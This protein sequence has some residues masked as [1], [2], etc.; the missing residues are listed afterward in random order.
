[1]SDKEQLLPQ[2]QAETSA[3]DFKKYLFKALSNWYLFVIGIALALLY[4]HWANKQIIPSYGVHTTLI[5]QNKGQQEDAVAGGLR[6]FSGTGSMDTEMGILQSYSFN[7][8][9]I[10]ELDFATSYFKYNKWASDIELYKKT[11]FIVHYDSLYEQHNWVPVY[12]TIIDS[13]K[14]HLSIETFEVETELNFGEQFKYGKFSFNITLNKDRPFN[15][16]LTKNKYFFYKL[17]INSLVSA[18]KSKLKIE[19]VPEGSS[20]LWIWTMG[21]VKEKEADYL[22]KLVEIF[23]RQRL[24]E[25]N[26]RAVSIIEFIDKQIEGV[27]DSLLNTEDR[28]QVFKQN[29]STL[30]I[31]TEAQLLLSRQDQIDASIS[32]LKSRKS[33]YEITYND[34]KQNKDI[35]AVMMPT[36]VGIKD[37][38]IE[39]L[40]S[41]LSNTIMEREILNFNIAPGAN[42][43]NTAVLD[44]KI[45]NIRGQILNHAKKSVEA[46]EKNI[47][48]MYK[49]RQLIISKIYGL[50]RS[51]RR[52][53]SIERRFNI[54]DKI[55]TNLITRRIEAEITQASTKA[56]AKILDT[57]LAINAEDLTQPK[58][59]NR[60]K[61]LL[62]G[63][64]IPILIIV[65]K[66][67][68]NVT[69][70]DK[71]EI[72]KGT[73]VPI[74]ASIGHN[75]K[76]T[77]LPTY[78]HPKSP[79]SESFRALR[80][81]LQYILKDKTQ[82]IIAT[83]SSVSGEG[84][85]FISQNIASIIAIAEKKTLLVGL[86][87][88]K[89]RL[90]EEFG[91]DNGIGL[92]TF[93]IGRNT[94]DEIILK[95][96]VKNLYIALS[97]PIP[98]NPAE[99]IESKK[100]IEFLNYAKA[101]FD[102][103][104]IDTPPIAIV[105]DALL[106]S[107]QV[108]AFIYVVRQKYS[109]KNVIKLIGEID[110]D[111]KLK[112]LNIVLNDVQIASNYSNKYGYGHGYGYGY[113]YGYG[114]GYYDDDKPVK[115]SIW[116]KI[117]NKLKKK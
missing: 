86:D 12:I 105:T 52:F 59:A 93:L 13:T 113:G 10:R 82:Q 90:Q 87:L 26:A 109:N 53:L 99:L 50:P 58:S 25:K 8:R 11:P 34:I 97:G 68:L 71:R 3:F 44:L 22:N 17:S 108:D 74:I 79:I 115:T 83:T 19:I 98:P 95:T 56:D 69:I 57:A 112:N 111:A 38:T 20:I 66:E 106:L 54:N 18:Y 62:V 61:A 6:L 30:D 36:V 2:E 37:I 41:E 23:I 4:A 116:K 78:D 85:S 65:A 100:M 1:M 94:A 16:A 91:Q 63:L 89:P 48:N 73:T 40:I 39:R 14:Y 70:E 88:R 72:E 24:E 101:K 103:I 47:N 110:K 43:P 51:E 27:S 107:E 117:K 31:S 46:A 92:T 28:M 102:Y 84:K 15:N 64:L 104:V 33:Y 5:K 9:A 45:N 42:L 32:Q 67:F 80:T 21:R 7:E 96:R 29:T 77:N 60:N 114:Q 81:N 55:Y 49:E 35:I 75:T 76:D